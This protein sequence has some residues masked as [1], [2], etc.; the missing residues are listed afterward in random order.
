MRTDKLIDSDASSDYTTTTLKLHGIIA[1]E[2]VYLLTLLE[3]HETQAGRLL[4]MVNEQM[5]LPFFKLR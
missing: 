5:H 2:Y 1:N 4:L 3:A